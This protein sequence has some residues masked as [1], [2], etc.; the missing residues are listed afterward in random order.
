M[1]KKHF[2]NNII[3]K[4]KEYMRAPSAYRVFILYGSSI[5]GK[6]TIAKEICKELEGFHELEF[7]K[8]ISYKS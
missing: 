3:I 7:S 4:V 6:T 5:S 2:I 1:Y 8:G